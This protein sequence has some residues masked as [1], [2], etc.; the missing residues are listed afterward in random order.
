MEQEE[1]AAFDKAFNESELTASI[2]PVNEEETLRFRNFAKLM[3]QAGKMYNS[4][5]IM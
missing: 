2:Y 4:S 1:L 3:W 5:S